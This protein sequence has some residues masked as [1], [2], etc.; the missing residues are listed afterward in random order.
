MRPDP[1]PIC[2]VCNASVKKI[3]HGGSPYSLKYLYLIECHGEEERHEISMSDAVN[4]TFR[5][6]ERV[7]CK[8][9]DAKQ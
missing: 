9:D 4:G 2:D 5:L 1:W 7:F 3:S 6:P 8:K